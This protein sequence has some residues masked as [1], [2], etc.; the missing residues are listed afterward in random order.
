[1]QKPVAHRHN[2]GSA[3][4]SYCYPEDG[5]RLTRFEWQVSRQTVETK[6]RS[7]TALSLFGSALGLATAAF[8][9]TMLVSPPTSEATA[10]SEPSARCAQVEQTVRPW[11]DREVARRARVGVTAGQA[12]FNSM[13]LSYQSAHAQCMSGRVRS[14]ESNLKRLEVQIAALADRSTSQDED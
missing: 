9:V 1:M 13:L 5:N 3:H 8:W 7:R 14:A 11:L 2:D 10:A 12:E 6:Q 4:Y